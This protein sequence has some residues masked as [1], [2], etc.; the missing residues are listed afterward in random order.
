MDP[1]TLKEQMQD[2]VDQ[3]KA[4]TSRDPEASKF[5]KIL[6]NMTNKAQGNPPEE[7][8]PEGEDCSDLLSECCNAL[9]ST[10]FGTS[11]LLVECKDCGK[12]YILRKLLDIQKTS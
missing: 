9:M 8:C 7:D 10:V 4:N 5:F 3:A 12:T 11:P 6:S 2:L 1:S